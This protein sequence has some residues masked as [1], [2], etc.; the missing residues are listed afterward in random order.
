MRWE[1]RIHEGNSN[2]ICV[3]WLRRP[4]P[5]RVGSWPWSIEL[6]EVRTRL[7]TGPAFGRAVLRLGSGIY[8]RHHHDGSRRD[9]WWSQPPTCVISK[10]ETDGVDP[11]C[12][13]PGSAEILW[14]R[15]PGSLPSPRWQSSRLI[16]TAKP[17]PADRLVSGSSAATRKGQTLCSGSGNE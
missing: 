6:P 8:E 11:G 13:R 14:S 16:S 7:Y 10:G 9:W 15:H 3:P 4:N 2:S 17:L 5:R 12:L 1:G